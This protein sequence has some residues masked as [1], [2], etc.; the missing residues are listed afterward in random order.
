MGETEKFVGLFSDGEMF[1]NDVGSE[2]IFISRS[3]YTKHPEL[4]KY[5]H[6]FEG[7]TAEE[8]LSTVRERNGNPPK[9]CPRIE[10]F[11]SISEKINKISETVFCEKDVN[12]VL[13]A[14][15]EG[16][17]IYEIIDF[18]ETRIEQFL[19]YRTTLDHLGIR[20]NLPKKNRKI[21]IKS[22]NIFDFA[23]EKK[24]LGADENG[25]AKKRT[26]E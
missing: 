21:V 2:A 12:P 16:I 25:N 7:Y 10:Y 1:A 24:K 22:I 26:Y 19:K 15:Y 14:V 20:S 5:F 4:S 13:S 9:C 8:I 23:E 11:G 18:N 17:V 6:I 3:F